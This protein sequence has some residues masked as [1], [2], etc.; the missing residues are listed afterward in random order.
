MRFERRFGADTRLLVATE[1]ILTRRLQADPLLSTF[2]TVVLDEF[3]ERSIHGDLALALL[4]EARD[5]PGPD[6]RVVVMSATLDAG[7]VASSLVLPRDRGGRAA[8][9]TSRST[10]RPTSRWRRPFVV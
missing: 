6:L 5:R 8:P 4:A 1:G 2:A 10:T 9:S 3:H 7:P